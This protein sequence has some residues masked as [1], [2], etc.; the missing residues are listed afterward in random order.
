MFVSG[1]RHGIA[2]TIARSSSN[3]TGRSDKR[4]GF[5][6]DSA[7][8]LQARSYS[9]RIAHHRIWVEPELAEIEYRAKSAGGASCGTVVRGP[10][11]GFVIAARRRAAAAISTARLLPPTPR[12]SCPAP[13]RGADYDPII[14][15]PSSMRTANA[16]RSHAYGFSVGTALAGKTSA[17]GSDMASM[18]DA[19]MG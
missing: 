13:G 18:S 7:K 12:L 16:L 19:M 11:E 3:K 15:R 9:K 4:I 1:L 2:S 14:R 6:G 8:E 17:P 5:D 10:A